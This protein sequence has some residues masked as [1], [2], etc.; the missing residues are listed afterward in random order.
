LRISN[1]S[2]WI[3][4]LNKVISNADLNVLNGSSVLVTGAT[5]LI[6]SAVVDMLIR[7]NLDSRKRDDENLVTFSQKPLKY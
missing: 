3:S 2:L 7:Y 4:D 1:S 5:G 6:C